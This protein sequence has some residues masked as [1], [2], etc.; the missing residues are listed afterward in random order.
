[1]TRALELLSY[2]LAGSAFAWWFAR[3][4]EYVVDQVTRRSDEPLFSF[5]SKGEE[6]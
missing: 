6:R 3:F 2:L 4:T 1:M 5:S